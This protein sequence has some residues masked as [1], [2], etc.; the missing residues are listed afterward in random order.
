M[1]KDRLH[2][3]LFR[4]VGIVAP[5]IS[6]LGVA[7]VDL[8]THYEHWGSSAGSITDKATKVCGCNQAWLWTGVAGNVVLALAACAVV[9]LGV[10]AV[11]EVYTDLKNRAEKVETP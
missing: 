5:L 6:V 11:I 3:E 4:W 9:L 1:K 10:G 7:V 2:F 8:F